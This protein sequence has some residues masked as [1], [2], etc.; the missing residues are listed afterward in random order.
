MVASQIQEE[1]DKQEVQDVIN[2][3]FK[4]KREKC[5]EFSIID[6]ILEY[7]Y[8]YDKN[9]QELGNIISEHEEFIQILEKQLVRT[10]Y[11]KSD[12]PSQDT[13]DENEW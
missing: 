3:I 1:L 10:H 4:F 5:P 2:D 11:I 13:L 12:E 8:K 6:T 7:A 9:I